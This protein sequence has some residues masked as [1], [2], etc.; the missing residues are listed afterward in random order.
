MIFAQNLKAG[1]TFRKTALKPWQTVKTVEAKKHLFS[2]SAQAER[3]EVTTADNKKILMY[4]TDRIII[5]T[6]NNG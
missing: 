1:D 6:E 3:I 4:K 5:K 2:G